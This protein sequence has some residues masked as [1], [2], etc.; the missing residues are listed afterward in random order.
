M[1]LFGLLIARWPVSPA[2]FPGW[3]S[4]AFPAPDDAC[5]DC[6]GAVCLAA[7]GS[8]VVAGLQQVPRDALESAAAMGMSGA[9]RFWHVQLPLALLVRC[10]ACGW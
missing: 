2:I 10:A 3:L 4:E 1:A 5:A 8:R 7:A 9:Q 6:A